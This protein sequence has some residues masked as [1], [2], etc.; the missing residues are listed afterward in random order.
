MV[1]VKLDEDDFAR[2]VAQ[3]LLW[4]AEH[5]ESKKVRKACFRAAVYYMTYEET[6][7]YF[8]EERAMEYWY[9]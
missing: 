1:K 4:S 9:E 5:A 6:V 7:E 8:G 2:A 3:D